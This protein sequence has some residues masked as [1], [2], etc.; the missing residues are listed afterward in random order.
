MGFAGDPKLEL[1]YGEIAV[2]LWRYLF[3][4]GRTEIERRCR[5]RGFKSLRPFERFLALRIAQ[6]FKEIIHGNLTVVI[7]EGRA[8]RGV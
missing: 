1:V 2:G 7:E 8:A 4:N 6:I 3:A 5:R